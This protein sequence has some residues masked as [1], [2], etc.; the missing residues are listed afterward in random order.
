MDWVNC[1]F[2]SAGNLE[3]GMSFGI[4]PSV[5]IITSYHINKNLNQPVLSNSL[6]F[7]KVTIKSGS[8]IRMN[9]VILPGVTIGE[10]AIIGAGSVVTKSI[11][12]YVIAIGS[13]A[14]QIKDRKL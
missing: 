5:Q 9:S 3:I 8:D 12:P 4:G 11:D 1:F 13:P 7:K 6:K 14:K 2:H 10:G